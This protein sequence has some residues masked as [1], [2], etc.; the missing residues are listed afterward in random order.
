MEFNLKILV[1]GCVGMIGTQFVELLLKSG[2]CVIG[3][4]NFSRGTKKNLDHL[5]RVS[6]KN[7]VDFDF[8]RLDLINGLPANL[9][10]EVDTVVHLADVVGGIMYVFDN[11]LDVFNLSVSID[12]NVV[13]AVNDSNVKKYIYAGTAC[14]FPQQIQNSIDSVLYEKDKYP[15]H[16]ESAYGW[17]KLV[18]ELQTN[19]LNESGASSVEGANVIFHNVYGPWCDFNLDTCQVIPALIKKA[20]LLSKGQKLE[21]WGGGDQARSF[22]HS[23]DISKFLLKMVTSKNSIKE[24]NGC[25]L[26]SEKGTTIN[27]LAAIVLEESGF[28]SDAIKH[29]NPNFRGDIGRIPDLSLSSNLGFNQNFDIKQGIRNLI[30]WAKIHNEI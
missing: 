19:Y 28:D 12:A 1:T 15:A 4:D 24:F 14:S 8:H 13:R 10:K 3:C 9:L 30:D 6:E 27:D 25:Q 20:S 7:K 23:Y 2:I 16:P 26:G 5:V 21:V 18:G 17:G 11:Q 22:V 29:I